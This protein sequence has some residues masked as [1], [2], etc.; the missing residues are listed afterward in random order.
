[1]TIAETVEWIETRWRQG[2]PRKATIQSPVVSAFSFFLYVFFLVVFFLL[3]DEIMILFIRSTGDRFLSVSCVAVMFC[4]AGGLCSSESSHPRP[5]PLRESLAVYRKTVEQ[6]RMILEAESG[7]TALLLPA[8][9][10]VL[11]ISSQLHG[12]CQILIDPRCLRYACSITTNK[13]LEILMLFRC[14][15]TETLGPGSALYKPGYSSI[16]PRNSRVD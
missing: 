14:V 16:F 10:H 5:R 2:P 12:V 1:M 6:C 3:S 15:P 4:G 11:C 7:S 9:L 13:S 8:F